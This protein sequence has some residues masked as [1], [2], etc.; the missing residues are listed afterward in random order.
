MPNLPDWEQEMEGESKLD[1]RKDKMNTGWSYSSVLYSLMEGVIPWL[2]ESIVYFIYL[3]YALLHKID[4]ILVLR[5]LYFLH[6]T[7]IP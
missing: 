2:N 3:H 4:V 7:N 6:Q 5:K 1:K